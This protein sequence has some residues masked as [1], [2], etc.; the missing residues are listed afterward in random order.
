[1]CKRITNFL[2]TNRSFVYSGKITY[3]VGLHIRIV[4]SCDI[5]SRVISGTSSDTRRQRPNGAK[6]IL[7]SYIYTL[8]RGIFREF[9]TGHDMHRQPFDMLF[10]ISF[11]YT[12]RHFKVSTILVWHIRRLAGPASQWC[13]IHTYLIHITSQSGEFPRTLRHVTSRRD[14]VLYTLLYCLDVCGASSKSML[15]GTYL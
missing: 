8:K 13:N 15:R 12:R 1:M 4:L 5:Y 10:I 9:D 2:C 11:R 14:N 6:F 7:T 3:I